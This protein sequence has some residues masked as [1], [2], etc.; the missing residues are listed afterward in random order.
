MIYIKPSIC[1]LGGRSWAFAFL[2]DDLP[3]YD[4]VCTNSHEFSS[5][6]LFDEARDCP[7]CGGE[8]R[9]KFPKRNHIVWGQGAALVDTY[10]RDADEMEN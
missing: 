5:L 2:G 4:F 8:S 9:R 1:L 10:D 7:E 3:L 6:A